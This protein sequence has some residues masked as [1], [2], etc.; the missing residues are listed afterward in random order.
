MKALSPADAMFLMIEQARMPMHVAGLQ[1]FTPPEG[2]G[3]EFVTELV[4]F[5]RRFEQPTTPFNRR[6][7]FRRGRWYWV[8]DE[9]FDL[10][11]HFR[12]S[13][14][15]H[16]GRVRELLTLVSRWHGSVMDRSRPL[17]EIHFIEGLRDQRFA[18]YGKVHH[19]LFDGVAATRVTLNTFSPDPDRR[20]MPP[21]WAL[22]EVARGRRDIGG[23]AINPLA[24][25]V[26]SLGENYRVLPGMVK[27][28]FELVRRR[29]GDPLDVRPYQAPRTMFNTRI[30]ASRRFA[31][32][33]FPIARI[34]AVGKA[35]GA[36]I[37]DV[38]LAMCAGALRE[39][40]LAHGA[41]PDE[42]L[43]AMVPVSVRA[44]D[45]PQ[46]GN[47]VSLILANLATQVAD[48]A[49]RLQQIVQSTTLA[50]AKLQQMT[51]V[52]QIAYAAASMSPMPV[53]T[54]LG[55]ERVRPPFNVV[56][57]NVPG[58][59]SRCTG[60]ARGSTRCTRSRSRSTAWP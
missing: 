34:R 59:A 31:A 10:E 41:L 22:P 40:L 6:P 12:H 56:I 30:S 27:G 21:A 57:S 14:L 13:A 17:W 11:H 7:M 52:E 51:R 24:A 45:G 9:D 48:P 54:L 39:Y 18:M 4:E 1:L 36:T 2:A 33:S 60:T 58:R 26:Q 20:D 32:Q 25:L 15:P 5:S 3:K 28:L 42:A 16:P 44:A 43:T 49:Q 23:A 37:N 19:A 8:E 53:T 46:D 50:K 47:Q 55:P 35:C 38:V 29:G